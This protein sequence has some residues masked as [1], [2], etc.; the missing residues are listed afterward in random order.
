MNCT[1]IK[2]HGATIKIYNDNNWLLYRPINTEEQTALLITSAVIGY[3]GR[4]SHSYCTV[5]VIKSFHFQFYPSKKLFNIWTNN[6]LYFFYGP[7]AQRG[8]WPPHSWWGFLITHNDAPQSVGLLWTSDQPGAET[9]TWQH[10]THTTDKYPCPPG[11]I[12]AHNLSRRAAANLRLRSRG[13]WDRHPTVIQMSYYMAWH[14][15]LCEI[16]G[17]PGSRFEDHC[18][19][20]CNTAQSGRYVRTFQ[21]ELNICGSV[22]HA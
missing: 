21:R 4:I 17:L 3:L 15:V 7:A 10:T 5:K 18:L 6:F 8:L 22:H 2:T 11:G 14:R 13:H 12:R 9:S 1:Y 16:W 20:A 19:L